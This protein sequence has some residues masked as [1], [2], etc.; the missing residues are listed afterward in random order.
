MIEIPSKIEIKLVIA[1]M[2]P[3]KAPKLGVLYSNYWNVILD[4]INVVRGFFILE[5][6][7]STF[8]TFNIVLIPKKD[9][10]KGLNDFRPYQPLQ[11][12]LQNH[13]ED[14]SEQA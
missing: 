10:P 13:F 12:C 9:N 5:R 4:V 6:L 14:L 1:A 3:W 11:L 7:P 2:K 8:N